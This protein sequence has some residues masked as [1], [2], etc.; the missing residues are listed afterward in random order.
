MELASMLADEP[1]SDQ[2]ESACPVVGMVLRS[3]NDG[4]DDRRRQDLYP[5]AARVSG[6]REPTAVRVRMRMC[7][8][9]FGIYLLG[10]RGLIP[11][12]KLRAIGGAALLEGLN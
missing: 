4:L 1:F 12:A 6:T 8:D 3:Y 10:W 5:Y 2:P 11:G 7:M 9:F